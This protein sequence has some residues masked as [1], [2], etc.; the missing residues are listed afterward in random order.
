M[1]QL[2]LSYSV[3]CVDCDKTDTARKQKQYKTKT[4]EQGSQVKQD[5]LSFFTKIVIYLKFKFIFTSANYLSTLKTIFPE[6]EV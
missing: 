5:L 2:H 6:R 4:L 1:N 3:L